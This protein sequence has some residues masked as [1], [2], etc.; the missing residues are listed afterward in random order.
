MRNGFDKKKILTISGGHLAHDTFS[1]FLAPLLPL[2]I[3][4]LGISLSLSAV[5]DITRKVPSLL[6]P[7]FGWIAEKTSVKYFVILTPSV[8]AI[9]MGLLGQ[10]ES[11][12][13]LII[14]LLIAG[15]SSALFH[16]PSPVMIREASGE[17]VGLGMSF[18]MVGGEAARTLGPLLLTGV[19]SLWGLEGTYRVIPLGLLVSGLLFWVLRDEN[20]KK[21]KNDTEESGEKEIRTTI[22]VSGHFAKKEY[23]FFFSA[24]VLFALCQAAAKSA[25]TLYLPTYLTT[26]GNSLYFAGISLSILQFSGVIGAFSAGFFSDKLGRRKILIILAAGSA[27][28]MW[29]FIFF[30]KTLALPVLIFLGLFL[31]GTGPVM[32]SYVHD[33][34]SNKPALI[35]SIYMAIN[36]GVSSLMVLIN[37]YLGDQ[38]NLNFTYKFGATLYL[39]L[40][41]AVF[42]LDHAYK[43]LVNAN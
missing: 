40:I 29:I 39:F 42:Y 19:L 34:K 41:P 7:L 25:F 17:R 31:F 43:K 20:V 23:F 32:L 22:Q 37:G 33:T 13:A 10:V 9:T 18:Y 36:F 8:T 6:N 15:V 4:K 11:Y 38:Y 16:I 2:L 5:L 1:A 35:N 12:T 24:I 27:I 21:N 26:T 3:A 28:F 30:S 14:M